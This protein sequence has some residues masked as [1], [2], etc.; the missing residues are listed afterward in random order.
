M[1]I[2][3][4]STNKINVTNVFS[5]YKESDD[6]MRKCENCDPFE[7]YDALVILTRQGCVMTSKDARLTFKEDRELHKLNKIIAERTEKGDR[8]N[9]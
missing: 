8:G 7:N 6:E 1:L 4:I 5:E 3:L 2:L 9:E